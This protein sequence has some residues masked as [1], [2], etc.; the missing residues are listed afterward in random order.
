M[1]IKTEKVMVYRLAKYL[2]LNGDDL[3]AQLIKK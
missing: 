1:L 3:C 2:I